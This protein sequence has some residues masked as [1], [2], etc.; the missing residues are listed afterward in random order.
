M[1][2]FFLTVYLCLSLAALTTSIYDARS[3][4]RAEIMANTYDADYYMADVIWPAHEANRKAI[5]MTELR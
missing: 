1:K 4:S 3:Y 5:L 2:W